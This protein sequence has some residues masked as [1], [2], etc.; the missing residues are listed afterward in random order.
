[1]NR[2]NKSPKIVFKNIE[3]SI[4]IQKTQLIFCFS[5]LIHSFF[6]QSQL[7]NLIHYQNDLFKIF[8]TFTLLFIHIFFVRFSFFSDFLYTNFTIKY[9]KIML[10]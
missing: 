7:M 9:L 2:F 3:T 4:I 10:I 8:Y 5:S 6:Y 1:M